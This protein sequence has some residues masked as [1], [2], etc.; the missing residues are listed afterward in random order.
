M[1]TVIHSPY[2]PTFAHELGKAVQD[3]DFDHVFT[4][5]INP[6]PFGATIDDGPSGLFAPEVTHDPTGD[7]EIF[8]DGWTALTGMTGQYAYHGA[9]MHPS[10]FIGAGIARVL[11][12]LAEDEAQT[13]AIVVVSSDEPDEEPVG[14]AI[15]CRTE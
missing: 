11:A 14:W 8:G 15:L 2:E 13:Y 3:I 5:S 10:E 4:L 9:V 1:R 6:N 7:V 12:E